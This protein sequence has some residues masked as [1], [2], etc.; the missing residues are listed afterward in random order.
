ML[1]CVHS[2]LETFADLLD[3]SVQGITALTADARTIDLFRISRIADIWD[4]NTFPLVSAACAPRLAR[5]G[6]AR[7]GLRWM[8]DLGAARREL[9]ID[10]NPAL[11]TMLPAA[12]PAPAAYR[13]YRSVVR[14]GSFPV[15]GTWPGTGP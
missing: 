6:Q 4:N 13:D 5:T 10:L 12:R 11:D 8:A 2:P 7:A 15:Q 3:R 14:P 9:M 1:G